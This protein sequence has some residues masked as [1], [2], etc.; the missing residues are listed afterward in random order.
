MGDPVCSIFDAQ[1]SP[2]S[3]KLF[4]REFTGAKEPFSDGWLFDLNTRSRLG[5]YAEAAPV[6]S[7]DGSLFVIV[8][9]NERTAEVYDSN[10]GARI[11][12]LDATMPSVLL[13]VTASESDSDRQRNSSLISNVKNFARFS[14]DNSRVLISTTEHLSVYD[15]HSGQLM[16][17]S[18]RPQFSSNRAEFSPDSTRILVDGPAP[19][20]FDAATGESVFALTACNLRNPEATYS[21]HGARIIAAESDSDGLQLFNAQS[22]DLIGWTGSHEMGW[23]YGVFCFSAQFSE[24]DEYIDAIRK[25]SLYLYNCFDCKLIFRHQ[26]CRGTFVAGF[27]V[28]RDHRWLLVHG[29]DEYERNPDR[30]DYVKVYRMGDWSDNHVLT[31]DSNI[32]FAGYS[33]DER[34]ISIGYGSGDVE[35]FDAETFKQLDCFSATDGNAGK[36][37]WAPDGKRIVALNADGKTLTVWRRVRPEWWWGIFYLPICWVFMIFGALLALSAMSDYQWF[38]RLQKPAAANTENPIAVGVPA[39]QT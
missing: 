19:E 38:A 22:G 12:G 32:A 27:H 1:F 8:R 10:D 18:D 30:H 6:F 37:Q 26:G 20:V 3:S 25:E 39:T 2:D 24:D 29:R 13:N 15:T 16:Y 9:S 33:P 28:T 35:T 36:V 4:V 31:R 11:C 34:R 14:P 7:P 5:T 17:F 23:R 21:H